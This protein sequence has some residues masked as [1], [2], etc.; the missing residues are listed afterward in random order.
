[1][2]KLR[3]F[4]QNLRFGQKNGKNGLPLS[5][6]QKQ[7][8][9]TLTIINEEATAKLKSETRYQNFMRWLADNGVKFPGVDYPV[10]FGKNGEL[11]G[12]AAKKDIP[13]MKCYLFVPQHLIINEIVCRRNKLCNKVYELHPEIFKHHHDAEYLLMI[14]FLVHQRLLGEKSFWYPFF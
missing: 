5:E 14:V 3:V 7:D 6:S 9:D 13:P 10:A 8:M 12:F 11:I 2:E 4:E 1:M